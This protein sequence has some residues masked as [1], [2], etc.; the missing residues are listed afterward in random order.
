MK[1]D[2]INKTFGD[3]SVISGFSLDVKKNSIVCLIGP[4]GCGKTTLLNIVAGLENQDCG[5]V[6]MDGDNRISY[7]F[8]EPR[9][10][11]NLTVL[12]NI[13]VPLKGDKKKAEQ[14]L[15]T[16]GLSDSLNKYPS[17]LSGG[18]RQRV[19]IARAFSFPSSVI[20]MDEPF[21]SLDVKIKNNL[22]QNFLELWKE[23]KKTVIWVTHD[24]AEAC[25]VADKIVCLSSHPMKIVKTFNIKE[26]RENRTIESVAEIQA[27]VFRILVK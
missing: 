1:I 3:T 8:Q 19:A 10:L 18:M 20:L 17:E 9:L 22:I 26:K 7:L 4:S 14:I 25:L 12:E 11:N 2:N 27:S 21:Q 15:E 16:V 6:E 24:I 5:T 23:N 13:S